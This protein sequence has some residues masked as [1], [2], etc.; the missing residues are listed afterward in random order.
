MNSAAVVVAG[1]AL[2]KLGGSLREDTEAGPVLFW[3][4]GHDHCLWPGITCNAAGE[5]TDV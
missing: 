1:A 2:L 3:Q 4:P 5:V